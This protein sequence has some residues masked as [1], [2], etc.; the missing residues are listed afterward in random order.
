MDNKEEKIIV[1]SLDFED[2]VKIICKSSDPVDPLD[3][4][5]T[6]LADCPSQG[7]SGLA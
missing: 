1:E 7:C 4:K 3:L 2:G 5:G 6:K